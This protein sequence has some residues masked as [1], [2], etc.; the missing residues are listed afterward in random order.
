VVEGV[1]L[2]G[3]PTSIKSIS[4]CIYSSNARSFSS[5]ISTTGSHRQL[6]IRKK[7]Q[8]LAVGEGQV[9]IGGKQRN[10]S[11]NI[12]NGGLQLPRDFVRTM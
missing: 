5:C 12:A 7:V 8:K 2:A 3:K 4:E 11:N 6:N 1:K 10:Q 9:V